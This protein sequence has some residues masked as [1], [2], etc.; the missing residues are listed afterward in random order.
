M[1]DSPRPV[2]PLGRLGI[3][4]R[5]I[6]LL[7]VG[8]GLIL[9]A[10]LG[11]GTLSSR[12][13]LETEL[14]H[15]ALAMVGE[16]AARIDTV[17][18]AVEN[19]GD[20]LALTAET[21]PLEGQA[22][23]RLL[24]RTLGE[25]REIFG[26]AAALRGPDGR[27]AR[28]PYV[29]RD[30]TRV[31][32]KDL[33]ARGDYSFGV[34]DWFTLPRDLA[35]PAWTEPYYDEG[36]GNAL[37]ATYSVPIRRGGTFL[38]V[39][40]CDISL[41]WLT[42]L[43]QRI[44]LGGSGYAFL[45][46]RAGSV[47]AHPDRDYI[48]NETLFSLAEA[49]KDEPLRALGRRMVR[50]ERD[51]VPYRSVHEGKD[52]WLGFAPV[53]ATGWSLGVMV[54]REALMATVLGLTRTQVG[55][56]LTGMVLLALL[57]AF[58]SRSI[59]RP[60]RELERA[61]RVVATGDLDAPLPPMDGTD[62]VGRL[63][64][65]FAAMVRDLKDRIEELK[66]N[67]AARERIESELRIA[68]TIQMGLVPKTFP[69]FPSREDFS[70]YALLDPAREVGG[71][72]FDFFMTDPEH[73]ALV[74]ADVSGKGM[75]AA[76][77]MAVTRTLLRSLAKETHEPSA[78]LR[79]LNDELA[80]DNESCMFVTIF[81]AL[82]DL[83]TGE[84]RYASAGHQHPYRVPPRIP[85][86]PEAPIRP[87]PRVKGPVAGGLP[88]MD[89]PEG[90]VRLDPGD[91]LL[92]YTDGVTEAMNPRE[93]L[94]GEEALAARLDT[95]RGLRCEELIGELRE[96]LRRFAEETPQSDDITLLAFRYERRA[97]ETP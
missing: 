82:V 48:M 72:F 90:S 78:L 25:Q 73:F 29:C 69:P 81:Y 57:V 42:D 15:K 54:P 67:T 11:Y 58:V 53:P 88:G 45:I 12:D 47:I 19:T 49:W 94:F 76:L 28:I 46:S 32:S 41:E 1:A 14:R 5:M 63:G 89:F 77:Y 8:T 22:S 20:A 31:V 92:F 16:A 13:L 55:L 71:D 79:R 23:Y 80:T 44:P 50:G 84:T 39:V 93:E 61:A 36:G 66:A 74:V 83:R 3:A 96:D 59:T 21:F 60:L 18:Q 64:A 68:R 34:M 27:I 17:A 65:S 33:A 24:E 62:E 87:L 7:T 86:K 26:M 51:F 56:G 9:A 30:G 97:P 4:G 91:L 95:L 85:G 43:L 40:T 6:C 70:L 52:Y 37:I 75:P 2:G 38:G 10:V 35:A